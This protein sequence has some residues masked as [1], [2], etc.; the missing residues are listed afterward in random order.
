[1]T[2]VNTGRVTIAA[3]PVAYSYPFP[4]RSILRT[5]IDQSRRL[6]IRPD[7]DGLS[8]SPCHFDA[9]CTKTQYRVNISECSTAYCILN[10]NRSTSMPQNPRLRSKLKTAI[11]QVRVEP[12]LKAAAEKAASLDHRT[13]TNWIEVLIIGRCKE[14]H[15]E[16]PAS[17]PSS[18]GAR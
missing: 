12:K 11:I 1:M 15:V 8:G 17:A 3:T 6:G 2:H 9:S 18:D 13:L 4:L 10:G 16:P 5:V 7:S 14:L